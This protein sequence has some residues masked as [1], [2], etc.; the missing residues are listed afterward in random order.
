MK[1]LLPLSLILSSVISAALLADDASVPAD[2]SAPA[3]VP[4]AE[5]AAEPAPAPAPAAEPAA[6]PAPVPAAEEETIQLIEDESV[7]QKGEGL[8]SPAPDPAST[9][10][11]PG[12]KPVPPK[13]AE[14]RY[15]RSTPIKLM[16]LTSNYD[17]PRFLAEEALKAAKCPVIV[18]PENTPVPDRDTPLTF[19]ASAKE[20][21]LTVKAEDLSR[22]LAFT[23]PLYLIV[24]GNKDVVPDIY[25]LAVPAKVKVI[26]VDDPAWKVNAVK[27]DNI[28]NTDHRIYNAYCRY[29]QERAGDGSREEPAEEIRP[30]AA[31]P[32]E[33]GTAA[34]AETD[35]EAASD[36]E[37]K[38]APIPAPAD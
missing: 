32:A 14:V 2:Q 28:L 36:D 38:L 23:R 6:A 10:N 34:S 4:A 7:P 3:P 17:T 27:L 1:P 31:A 13:E 37:V 11:E 19:K 16:I 35:D 21:E 9:T 29:N 15:K 26:S 12:A 33:A 18:I 25:R 22:F 20:K 8:G 30:A 5:S 24:L